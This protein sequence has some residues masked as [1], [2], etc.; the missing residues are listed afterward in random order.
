[1]GLAPTVNRPPHDN[2][3]KLS[4]DETADSREFIQ[5]LDF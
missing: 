1:M 4:K 2:F 3:Q 5:N